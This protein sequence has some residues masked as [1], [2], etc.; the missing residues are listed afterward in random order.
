[1]LPLVPYGSDP[2]QTWQNISP[3]YGTTPGEGILSRSAFKCLTLANA[4]QQAFGLLYKI[5]TCQNLTARSGLTTKMQLHGL[6]KYFEF[7]LLKLDRLNVV[8]S[9]CSDCQ[10]FDKR[11]KPQ[12]TRRNTEVDFLFNV[13]PSVSSVVN[14]WF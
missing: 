1:M 8:C 12:R 14:L 5:R 4:S 2:V 13:S 6:V 10:P 11:V 9:R 3:P 7:N